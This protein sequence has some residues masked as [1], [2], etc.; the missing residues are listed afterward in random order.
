[1]KILIKHLIMFIL[2]TMLS[3]SLFA[4]NLQGYV[5]DANTKEKILL[6]N[7]SFLKS[8]RGTNTNDQ[9]MYKIDIS[10]HLNDSIKISYVGYAFKP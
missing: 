8:N 6:C 1:M 3:N 4:Q 10:D 5:Y 9:G 7:I 2:I